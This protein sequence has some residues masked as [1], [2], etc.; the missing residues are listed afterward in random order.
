V[1][2]PLPQFDLFGD[3]ASRP[4]PA[5]ATIASRPEGGLP[6]AA[7]R[8]RVVTELDANLLVEAGAGAGKTTEMVKRMVALVGAGS[9]VEHIAA[10]TFTRKAAAE[11]RERFQTSLEEELRRIRRTGDVEATKVVDR[12]LREIDRAFIGTIHAFC[13]RLLRERPLEAGV[14]PSFRETFAI[15]QDRLRQEFFAT[16]I[17]RLAAAGDSILAE[18]A[19][20]GLRPDQLRRLFDQL[21]E[22]GD[23]AFPAQRVERPDPAVARQTL[24]DLLDE[25]LRLMP[26]DEPDRGWD[27]LQSTIRRLRF[28]RDVV[29]WE[30]DIRFLHVLAENLAALPRAIYRRWASGGGVVDVVKDLESR[31]RDYAG[32]E[33][34]G[35]RVLR[36]WWAHRYPIAILFARGAARAFEAERLRTGA[37]SFQDL[38][39][40]TARLLRGNPDARHDL[41]ER[42]RHI[43]VDEFQ[44]TDPMQAEILFLL[45][46]LPSDDRDDPPDWRTVVPRPG[47]LFVVG[48]PKQSIYRFR[49][50]D[51]TIYNQV[52]RRFEEI[53]GVVSLTAN[54]RSGPPIERLVDDVFAERF[55]RVATGQQAAFA[56]LQVQRKLEEGHGV[57][58]YRVEKPG[59]RPREAELAERD[60][61]RVASWI[62]SRVA[63]GTRRPG[64]FLVL[65]RKKKHLTTYAREIEARNLPV[66]VTGGG[67]GI[68]KEMSEL[69]LL[70]QALA[71]PGDPTYTVATLIGLFFGLDYEQLAGY[72]LDSGGRLEFTEKPAR[73]ETAVETA[74]ERMHDWWRMARAE[75]ADVFVSKLVYELGLLQLAAA[76]SLG[77]SRAGA[78]LFV[79]EA[80]RAAALRGDASL[81]G[82]IG[83]IDAAL[84]TEE[85]EAPL[86][87]G[88]ADAV[89]VMNLHQAKGL[90]ARVVILAAPFGEWRPAPTLHVT[91]SESG[92]EGR[93]VVAERKWRF[94]DTVLAR[95]LDWPAHEEAER[96][97]DEAERDRLL[98]VAATRAMDELLI[99]RYPDA[100]ESPW[101]A[102]EPHLGAFP[103]LELPIRPQPE[104]DHIDVPV[105][106]VRA[107]IAETNAQRESLAVPTWEAA[108]VRSRVK[109]AALM[110]AGS[111]DTAGS[112]D[113]AD[114][115]AGMAWG[116]LVH[117]SLEAAGRGASGE[118]LAGQCRNILLATE[119]P[120]VDE[121]GEPVDLDRLIEVVESVT[122]S[123]LWARAATATAMLVE[124]P[125]SIALPLDE[126]G[127]LAADD[128]KAPLQ[129]IDGVIDLAFRED[130]G[131]V[132]VDYKSD[133]AGSSVAPEIREA[134]RR[135][136]ELYAQC[137]TRLTGER[138]SERVLLFTTD[139]EVVS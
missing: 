54:F 17:E 13:A 6:D 122:R 39:M 72:V 15:E 55:P 94:N 61:A 114:D 37:L 10:V 85:A 127:T 108:A 51:I 103:V 16:H 33:G 24:E 52:K 91:R 84:D 139:G 109:T 48:D 90:E 57:Y 42:Y 100:S 88:R 93:I 130:G 124:V 43:L 31:F 14:D 121:H 110:R 89:R 9:P 1:T 22:H 59:D 30:D 75:P 67:V 118:A 3:A 49:R 131:W 41:G 40:C 76:G 112:D 83:A 78:L 29:G 77:E 34:E 97:F 28:Y 79:L 5:V 138:V 82:A 105:A 96:E 134:Y 27:N 47:S 129:V 73:V 68:E 123:E 102:F 66:Q 92:A 125:F 46:S 11:L 136:V 120:R 19:A 86:E 106:H 99:S 104:R 107:L 62:E 60:A 70:L 25:A 65:T 64:D 2:E 69:R 95:P 21:T 8:L 58:S 119:D 63:D 36:Q 4:E 137:W 115:E 87:P 111:G 20:V 101:S 7:E 71:D 117:E 116:K 80:V 45:T 126:Y 12:A 18:L 44:D 35:G 38:L 74:L 135:Q 23:V 133:R 128:R 56:P 50:A 81:R 132:I 53:G 32:E 26:H 98:Y 113:D